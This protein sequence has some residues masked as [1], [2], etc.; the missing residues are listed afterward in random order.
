MIYIITQA[1]LSNAYP[2]LHSRVMKIHEKRLAV[3]YVPIA[4]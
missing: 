3:L 1:P 2:F 4:I